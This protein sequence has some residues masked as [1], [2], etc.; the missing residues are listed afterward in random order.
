MLSLVEHEKSFITS[1]PDQSFFSIPICI[2]PF[3]Y[4][5]DK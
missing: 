5:M 4:D 2:K 1:I 3:F